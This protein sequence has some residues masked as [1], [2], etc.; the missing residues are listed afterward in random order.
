MSR[1]HRYRVVQML[2]EA[3]NKISYTPH[4]PEVVLASDFD[5]LQRQCQGANNLADEWAEKNEQLARRC[6]E[7]ESENAAKD[8]CS[9]NLLV[10]I[11][12]LESERDTLRAEVEA[13]RSLL[14]ECR[15]LMQYEVE[16]WARASPPGT[17]VV[18]SLL[19]RIDAAMESGT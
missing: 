15:P 7:P 16:K 17:R 5:K 19:D 8:V 2:S 4:G 10:R 18:S 13:L 6:N 14:A 12:E 1:I 9:D 3:G 11:D